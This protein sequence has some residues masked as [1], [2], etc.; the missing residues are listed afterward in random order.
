MERSAKGRI[1]FLMF[2]GRKQ[3]EVGEVAGGIVGI[4]DVDHGMLPPFTNCGGIP[5]RGV[6]AHPSRVKGGLCLVFLQQPRSDYV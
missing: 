4:A 5:K 6:V 2:I 1:G 3:E